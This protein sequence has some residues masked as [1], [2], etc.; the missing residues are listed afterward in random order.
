MTVTPVPAPPVVP[1]KTYTDPSAAITVAPGEV[2]ILEVQSEAGTAYQWQ[3]TEEVN[4]SM[5]KFLGSEFYASG[6]QPGSAGVTDFTFEALGNGQETIKL[7]LF[8]AGDD[9]PTQQAQFT[10]NIK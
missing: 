8:A 6:S 9:Q 7:G 2:F 3:L 10:V 4:T 5:F 1:P